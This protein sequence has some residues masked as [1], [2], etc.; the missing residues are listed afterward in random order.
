M[1]PA[2][3]E[4]GK[5]SAGLAQDRLT[6]RR[7]LIAFLLTFVAARL[8]ALLIMARKIPDLFLHLG[9]THV[10]HLNH[11]IFLLAAVGGYLLLNR[12]PNRRLA[13]AL[14]GVGMGLTF[15]EFGM[16]LHLGGSYWQRASWDAV[17]VIAAGLA[18]FAYGPA[19]AQ[20]RPRHW[21]TAT[22]LLALVVTFFF[23]LARSLQH[24][25]RIMLPKLE[26][27]EQQGPR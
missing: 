27:I 12:A 13:C 5:P 25:E 18:L 20:Y 26:R 10:H 21:V 6:A 1:P 7:I 8:L 22:S 17:A 16:W 9:G 2:N 14:Y 15:D 24:A 19:L 3:L 11:G 23:L 4:A